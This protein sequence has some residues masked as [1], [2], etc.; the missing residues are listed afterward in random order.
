MIPKNTFQDTEAILE[1]LSR[2]SFLGGFTGEQ[3]DLMLGYFERVHFQA[4]E[5][6][7][8]RVM[9]CDFGRL[10]NCLPRAEPQANKHPTMKSPAEA[11]RRRVF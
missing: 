4:G 2:I 5:C 3:L 11:R 1:V 9:F 6:I 7:L 8:P 10:E